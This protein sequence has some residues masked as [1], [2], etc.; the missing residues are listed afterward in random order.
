MGLGKLLVF[1]PLNFRGDPFCHHLGR[2][3]TGGLVWVVTLPRSFHPP[4][5]E[6]SQ[7]IQVTLFSTDARIRSR[8]EAVGMGIPLDGWN[9]AIHH[10]PEIYQSLV[11]KWGQ[12]TN[13]STRAGNSSIKRIKSMKW[14][15]TNCCFNLSH[16]NTLSILFFGYIYYT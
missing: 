7:V 12:A 15:Q 4:N 14:V 16:K 13:L 2:F 1:L 10:P 3:P 6:G 9:P 8:P 11:N 5:W